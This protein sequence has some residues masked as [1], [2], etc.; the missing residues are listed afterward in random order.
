MGVKDLIAEVSSRIC[1]PNIR[2]HLDLTSSLNF[3]KKTLKL[4]AALKTR[5]RKIRTRDPNFIQSKILQILEEKPIYTMNLADE[6]QF[7]IGGLMPHLN[8]LLDEK[9]IIK[10]GY[11]NKVIWDLSLGS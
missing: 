2:Q 1:S 4:N 7:T 8:N 11:K 10:R 9:M 6:L 3:V 5:N